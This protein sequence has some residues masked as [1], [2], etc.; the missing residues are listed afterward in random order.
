MSRL[1][2]EPEH[3]NFFRKLGAFI[4]KDTSIDNESKKTIVV[5]RIIL[6]SLILYFCANMIICRSLI[7]L[8]ELTA[9]LAF[10]ILFI[11]IFVISYSLNTFKVLTAF[12]ISILLWIIFNLT[13]LGWNIGVQH[14]LVP[15]LFLLFFSSYGHYILKGVFAASTCALRIV[16]YL[17]YLD[18]TPFWELNRTMNIELQIAN[19]ITIFWCICVIAYVFSRGTH[20][21]EGKLVEYNARLEKQANT[22]TLTGLSNRRMALDYLDEFVRKSD[23]ASC[24]SICICDIDFFKK[25]NDNYGHDCGDKVLAQLAKIFLEEMAVYGMAARWGGEEFL[26]IFPDRNGDDA[27]IILYHI[28]ER[29]KTLRFEHEGVEFGV[30]LTYGL[31]EYDFRHDINETLIAA[32]NKLYQGKENGRNQIVY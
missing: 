17:I 31:A 5:I 7:H 20:E 9:Y 13:M 24:L 4:C 29:I 28:R 6:L 8:E 14:F 27:H 11:V 21:L 12:Y 18:R 30:T 1:S 2:S 26:L 22:D 25:I 10:L 32:D 23:S 16:L 3:K 19:T 15:L